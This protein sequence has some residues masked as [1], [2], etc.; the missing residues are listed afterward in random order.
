MENIFKVF[1]LYGWWGLLG[2]LLFVILFFGIKYIFKKM[3]NNI[4]TNISSGL[5]KV[6]ENL[7]T[8]LSEQNKQLTSTII[9]QQEKLINYLINNESEREKNHSSMLNERMSL[10]Q[11]INQALKD[12][13]N[14]HHAQRAF[15]LEFHNSYQNLNFHS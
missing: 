3:S 10:A 9:G 14:I 12:I 11:D 8:Q 1:E 2:L 7:T 5:E 4:T 15:I 6:G 13:M